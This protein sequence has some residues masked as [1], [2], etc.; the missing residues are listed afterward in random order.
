MDADLRG[1]GR[2]QPAHP[3]DERRGRRVARRIANAHIEGDRLRLRIDD[4]VA[5]DQQEAAVALGRQVRIVAVDEEGLLCR[6]DR[7]G[8]LEILIARVRCGGPG[9]IR[10]AE[11][12]R[13]SEGEDREGPMH[14]PARGR[15]AGCESHGIPPWK[16]AKK[17][18]GVAAAVALQHLVKD[19][20]R[21]RRLRASI[22]PH[23]RD[24]AAAP[25]IG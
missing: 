23:A 18:S 17:T 1:G 7:T 8:E 3:G 6:I 14:A 24:D 15:G 10:A 4:G 25:A 9:R 20:A 5:P 16:E 19:T 13:G 2:T 12:E 21:A 22:R 11:G